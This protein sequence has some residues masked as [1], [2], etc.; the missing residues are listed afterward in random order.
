MAEGSGERYIVTGGGGFIG[1]NLVAALLS[2]RPEA[3]LLVVDDFRSGSV[4]NI[5]EACER[6]GVPPYEG[7]LIAESTGDLDWDDVLEVVKPDAVFHLAAITDTTEL[8]ERRMLLDN[9]EGFRG[10]LHACVESQTRLVYAS[11]AATYGSPAEGFD[12]IPFPESS[13]GK[14]NNVYGF[15]KWMMEAI[16]RKL[17]AE[18]T[19][20]ACATSTCT[21][22][23]RGGR[24]RWHPC[25]TS[26]P[27]R[28]SLG[29]VR[30]SSPA[31]SRRATRSTWT[32]WWR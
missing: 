19:S 15:S 5:V 22:P 13:A 27:G 7:D 6:R 24:E 28:S 20:S 16:H 2:K 29:S 8:D 18:V 25:H 32:T 12:R 26:S 14:P 10:L 30:G 17:S 11:S 31:V 4:I 3:S 21:A 1:S 9:V 23:G